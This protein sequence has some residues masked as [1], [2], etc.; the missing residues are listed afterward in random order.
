MGEVIRKTKDGRFIGWY[1]R[2]VGADGKRRQRASHARS[3]AAA[4]RLLVQA[5]AGIAGALLDAALRSSSQ[6]LTLRELCERFCAEYDSPV[7]KD[8]NSYRQQAGFRLRRIAAQAPQVADLPLSELSPAHVAKARE[9]LRR[10]YPAGTVRTTMTQLSAALSWAVAEGLASVNAARGV[11]LP[12]PVPPPLDFLTAEEVRQLLAE[13]EKRARTTVGRHGLI[14]WAQFVAI[15]LAVR[16]G[17]RK[18]EV[19]GLR[20]QDVDTAT[21]RL[22]VSRSYATLPKSGK[23][24]HLRLPL[25]LVPVLSEWS[26][27]CPRTPEGVVCPVYSNHFTAARDKSADHGLPELMEAAGCRKLPR[28]W[29]LLR[30][31]FASLFVQSGGNLLSLSKILG[32]ADVKTTMVYAHL[33]PDYLADE[34]DKLKL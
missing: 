8:L 2:W 27:L 29:H 19:F 23:P 11:K 3:H 4:R 32:H 6:G 17:L 25:A 33:S 31:S 21:R 9:A 16:T 24:R 14:A 20:W 28:R 13:S 15:S 22:T 26:A 12:P 7:L 18:G 5:E 10:R 34:M 30:H 1:I